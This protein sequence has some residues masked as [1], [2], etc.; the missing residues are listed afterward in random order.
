MRHGFRGRRFNRTAE[1]RQAMFANLAQALINADIGTQRLG[2][3]AG[4]AQRA[5][6][7]GQVSGQSGPEPVGSKL[8]IKAIDIEAAIADARFDKWTWMADQENLHSRPQ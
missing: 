8:R 3:A 5:G 6:E 1:H 4:T 7:H 2:Q